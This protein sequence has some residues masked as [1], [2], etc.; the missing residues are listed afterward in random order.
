M[1]PMQNRHV[2]MVPT[3]AVRQIPHGHVR[4]IHLNI[5]SVWADAP[6]VQHRLAGNTEAERTRSMAHH[7]SFR[8]RRRDCLLLLNGVLLAGAGA[9]AGCASGGGGMPPEQYEGMMPDGVVTM[10][11]V[12]AAYIGSGSTGTGTLSFQGQSYPFNVSGLGVGGIGVSE[13]QAQGYVYRLRN[14]LEFPGTYGQAR[15]GFAVGQSSAGDLLMQNAAGVIMRLRAKRE[16][17]MLSLGA[18]A[19]VISMQ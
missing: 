13:I 7:E 14:A 3:A 11:Q 19:M 16:G 12:Q 8:L 18:D 10:Q 6:E 2:A 4:R 15:Y 5:A 17:L 9:L 1:L